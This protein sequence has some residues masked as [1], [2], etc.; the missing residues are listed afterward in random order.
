MIK[1]KKLK[2]R[3]DKHVKLYLLSRVLGQ[4]TRNLTRPPKICTT[5]EKVIHPLKLG[6]RQ[7]FLTNK[8]K[9]NIIIHLQF[10][11]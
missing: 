3:L 1:Q 11:G 6:Q 2:L 10:V 8:V 9:G 4:V 5:I 7:D